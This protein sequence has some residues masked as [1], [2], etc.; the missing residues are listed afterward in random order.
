ERV[1]AVVVR[2]AA[3]AL[4]AESGSAYLLSADG[5]ALEL[6]RSPSFDLEPVQPAAW[7]VPL[8][9]QSLITEAVRTC[10]P[11]WRGSNAEV[12]AHDS[13]L[14]N[15]R[16]VVNTEAVAAIPFEAHGRA[17]GGMVLSSAN[18]GVPPPEERAF[19]IMLA[20]MCGQA[21]ERARL[22]EAERRARAAAERA[23]DRTARLQA[24]TAALSEAPTPAR[25][26]E[27]VVEQ[28]SAALGAKTVNFLQISDESATL[29][30]V[31]YNGFPVEMIPEP[32]RRF[33]LDSSMPMAE[34]IRTGQPLWFE[35]NA[36]LAERWPE[37]APVRAAV[38]TEA[39]VVVPL[40]AE[41]RPLGGFAA[42]FTQTGPI[43]PDDREFLLALGQV[44]AQALD[45]ARLFES[46]RQARA[47]L[48]LA[49][50]RARFLAE[51]GEVLAGSLDYE[52]T[53]G[54]IA[55][56]AVPL[57]ADW[58][59]VDMLETDGRIAR[60]A[61]VHADPAHAELAELIRRYRPD[62]RAMTDIG[63]VLRTGV[64]RLVPDYDTTYLPH[65]AHDRE[66][67]Q[68]IHS[69]GQRSVIRVPLVAHR[70]VL[71][72]IS[73]SATSGRRYGPDDLA[74][75]EELA[76]RASLAV[77]NARLY[78][79][80]QEAVQTREEFLSVAAHELRTPLASL[81]GFTQLALRRLS[82]ISEDDPRLE[83]LLSHVYQQANRINRLIGQLLDLSRIQAGRLMLDP[84]ATDL[85]A[86][87][88][89]VVQAVQARSSQQEVVL[90]TPGELVVEAD[91][92]RL[93]QV[94]TNLLD[95]ALKYG[96]ED[97]RI[98]V[99]VADPGDARSALVSIRDHGVGIPTELHDQIFDRFFQA[100]PDDR[101]KGLGLGLHISRQIVDL[102]GGTIRAEAPPDGG[103]RFVIRL[104]RQV[105]QTEACSEN[106]Q[107]GENS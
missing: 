102:H 74:L 80:A 44:C 7:R 105:G 3:E 27:V 60:V 58:C 89:E 99:E 98:E 31:R 97:Q 76:R 104:P 45:R 82:Q 6:V 48:E 34:S 21:L 72:V 81:L 71:G 87:A 95:N 61:V 77:E 59:V 101:V 28:I 36:E 85:S 22:F 53:L 38:G 94:L 73:L 2:E 57:L 106:S 47:R 93:E 62:P 84:V 29:E 37:L 79:Q 70:Q 17:L 91:P 39:L 50:R 51:A 65:V 64:P 42:S 11:V 88:E 35:S 16:V 20:Q 9:A 19:A 18:A 15:R 69:M 103:I 12:E 25:V 75:A 86:L 83:T 32:Y 78:R 63:T 49:E 52:T 68:A 26:A 67:I 43:A 33:P 14:A 92:L 90:K 66:Y 13:S 40:L 96:P 46:E 1:A 24:A 23:A 54:T 4:E 30:T 56:L 5:T 100:R 107:G 41:G 55:Q 8:A 10:Q